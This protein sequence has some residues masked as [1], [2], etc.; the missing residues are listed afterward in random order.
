MPLPLSE[1]TTSTGEV[2]LTSDERNYIR[3]VL[4]V[5]KKSS[6]KKYRESEAR[7]DNFVGYENKS[8]RYWMLK[9]EEAGESIIEIEAEGA[10]L[11]KPRLRQRYAL[12]LYNLVFAK[13]NVTPLEDIQIEKYEE[14]RNIVS[15]VPMTFEDTSTSS[16][17]YGG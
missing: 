1:L 13:D 5:S 2:E 15:F 17:E 9:Y 10:S 16:D 4:G 3:E 14:K 7:F 12:A 6:D 11:S 8:A